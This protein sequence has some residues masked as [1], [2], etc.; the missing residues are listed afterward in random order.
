MGTYRWYWSA[1]IRDPGGGVAEVCSA[2]AVEGFLGR[3]D[4]GT[5]GQDGVLVLPAAAGVEGEAPVVGVAAVAKAAQR[6]DL[7]SRHHPV[8]VSE[9]SAEPHRDVLQLGPALTLTARQ[10]LLERDL[11]AVRDPGAGTARPAE[12]HALFLTGCSL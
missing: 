6:Q 1:L 12:G 4:K 7:A 2:G 10:L 5:G 11:G 9:A 3:A 8:H